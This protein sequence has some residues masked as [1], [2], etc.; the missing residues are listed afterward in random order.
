MS[1]PVLWLVL[2]EMD[3]PDI[4]AVLPTVAW[5]GDRAGALVECY[6][7]AARDGQLFA[8]HG[9]TVLGGAHH[10][11]F[12]YLHLVFD[13]RAILY[14]TPQLFASSLRQF[15]TPILAQATTPAAL[16]RALL[17][18][19]PGPA[20]TNAVLLP[21][22]PVT[23]A[24]RPFELAP[25]CF[26]EVYF[27]QALGFTP[28][29]DRAEFAALPAPACFT[30]GAP[31]LDAIAPEDSIG[32]V[33]LR[34]ARR[35][36]ARARGVVFGDPPAV[37]AQ[38]PTHCRERRVAVYAP[39]VGKPLREVTSHPYLEFA[40]AIADETA[41]LAVALGN[42]VIV[43][44]QTGDADLFVWARHGVCIRIIDPNRPAFPVVAT[45]PHRWT[46]P[47]TPPAEPEP[48]DD[49]LRRYAREGRRLST[50]I[51]HSG[52]MAHNEAMLNF[53]ELASWSG[54]KLGLAVHDVRYTSCPQLWE[55]L[56]TPRERGGVRG[57]VEPVLH[58]GG[59]GVMAECNCPPALLTEHCRTAL[60][61]IRAIA[62]DAG[63]PRGYYAFCDTDL[64][65][66]TAIRPD[67]F[68]AVADA[69]LDYF[70]SSAHPGRNLL[71]HRPDRI[72]VLNQTC[73]TFCSG[74]PFV[75][76]NGSEGYGYAAGIS[77]GWFIATLDAPVV[78]FMPYIWREGARYMQ[79][80][81]AVMGRGNL[82]VTPHVVARYARMLDE[83]GLLPPPPAPAKGP[84]A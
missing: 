40:S 42:R 44:R 41:Q 43:G 46:A 73:R 13:V 80:F 60:A 20:P 48:S 27:R 50:L 78:A 32:S 34:L 51:V 7:E 67:L 1:K 17:P 31:A 4:P 22:A 52:E 81:D 56:A 62:G 10:L 24:G 9:S 21:D 15:G 12:N 45:V 28:A 19:A 58:A 6:L 38:L 79:L 30:P 25:Y 53:C 14:G 37:L 18:H 59:R 54:L 83:L 55:L 39:C 57:L 2:S 3:N 29:N 82:N 61:E 5:L 47:T 64:E 72:A 69:G 36:Q 63:T 33:T 68:A 26:P 66:T 8:R 70:I 11:Q 71:L 76:I 23:I 75:R 84:A 49:E 77:P 65:T 74:S 35:W 16:Y